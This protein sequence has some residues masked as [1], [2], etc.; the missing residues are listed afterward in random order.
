[1]LNNTHMVIQELSAAEVKQVAGGWTVVS[2][3]KSILTSQQPIPTNSPTA[4]IGIRG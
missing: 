4:T 3:L 2:V 1:M